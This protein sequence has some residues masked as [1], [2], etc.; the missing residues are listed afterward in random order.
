MLNRAK[1]IE[2]EINDFH[3]N[4]NKKVDEDNR[5]YYKGPF[6]TGQLNT[7]K[8]LFL[9]INPGYGQDEWEQREK[10]NFI[11]QDFIEEPCKYLE[12]Y[13]SKSKLASKIKDL[14]LNNDERLFEQCTETYMTSFFSTP[15]VN[16][17]NK[18]LSLLDKDDIEK[19]NDLMNEILSFCL[20]LNPDHIICIGFQAFEAALAKF[21]LKNCEPS[22]WDENSKQKRRYYISAKIL[23]NSKEITI[24][25]LRHLSGGRLSHY[26][27][28][29][30]KNIFDQI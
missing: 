14:L 17:L 25:G 23:L 19:H 5:F 8:Y 6:I 21:D 15:N 28:T 26:M 2:R 29:E 24:H 20:D 30:I 11:Q 10:Y 7:P 1:V 27:M 12:E 13:Q 3:I 16:V 18:Q 22:L 4:V 9:S